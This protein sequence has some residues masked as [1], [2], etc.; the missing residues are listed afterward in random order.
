MAHI[1]AKQLDPKVMIQNILRARGYLMRK[2][3][4]VE[5]KWTHN[6]YYINIEM[7]A[8]KKNSS[9]FTLTLLGYRPVDKLI[10]RS[11]FNQ[12]HLMPNIP[13]TLVLRTVPL[14]ST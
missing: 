13:S 11:C 3:L 8:K 14:S 4:K 9:D 2:S 1:A 6:F 10:D 12:H 5:R 7:N